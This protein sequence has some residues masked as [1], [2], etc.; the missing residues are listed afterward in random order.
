MLRSAF[1]ALNAI[2]IFPD[3]KINVGADQ[4]GDDAESGF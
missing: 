2:R 3:V 4:L 1:G